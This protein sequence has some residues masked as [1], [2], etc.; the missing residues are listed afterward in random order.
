MKAV[1]VLAMLAVSAVAQNLEQIPFKTQLAMNP[2]LNTEIKMNY[3]NLLT[4]EEVMTHPLF[5]VYYQL[6]LFRQHFAH[7]LFQVYLTTPQ[8]QNYWTHPV[9]PTFFQNQVL[10]YK[11]IY[12]VVYKDIQTPIVNPMIQYINKMYNNQQQVP[13]IN[14]NYDEIMRQLLLNVNN[15]EDVFRT[16][17]TQGNIFDKIIKNTFFGINK[18]EEVTEV[19]TE[20]KQ[21]I[22]DPIT[23]MNQK[24]VEESPIESLIR[25]D[26]IKGDLLK[27]DLV[28]DDWMNEAL[29][30]KMIAEKM[31]LGKNIYGFNRFNN[32]MMTPEDFLLQKKIEELIPGVSRIRRNANYVQLPQYNTYNKNVKSLPFFYNVPAT[33]QQVYNVPTTQ[34]YYTQPLNTYNTQPLNTYNTG[35]T[36]N[37]PLTHTNTPFTYTNTPYVYPTQVIV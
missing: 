10:F 27:V 26:L 8:F 34:Y 35:Y 2:L 3:D 21:K 14:N 19:K 28:K 30:K 24:F 29:Y 4:L 1:F 25:D 31:M 33:T 13:L 9:F 18:P 7:P 12:P 17:N 22:V 15:Q 20:V 16:Y 11:Y 6:P 5:R 23:K 36:Y 32:K 37:T